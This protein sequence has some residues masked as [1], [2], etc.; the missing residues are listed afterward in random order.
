MLEHLFNFSCC[1]TFACRYEFLE[2][3]G[4]GTF[5]EVKLARN[6]ETKELVAIKIIYKKEA[7]KNNLGPQVRKEINIMK[8][9]KHARVVQVKEVLA[10]QSK[11][12]LVMEYISG[13]DFRSKIASKGQILLSMLRS[14]GLG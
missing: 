2:T 4:E 9:L 5:A 11:I 3:L 7:A 14:L 1:C 10:S 6:E 8:Q 12:F 13:G